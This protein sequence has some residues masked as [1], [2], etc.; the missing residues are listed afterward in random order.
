MKFLIHSK[1]YGDKKV[2]IDD[3]DWE[4][5]SKY[6]W[7]LSKQSQGLL[8]AQ[9]FIYKNGKKIPLKLHRLIMNCPKNKEIDHIDGNG[10]NNQ[11]SNLRICT[12]AENMKNSKKRKDNSSGFKGIH[13]IKQN[14][15][16]QARI[17]VNRKRMP[18]GCYKTPELA[19][20]AYCK[21]S[22]KYH[23]EFGRIK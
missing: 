6:K 19:Y 23:G 10:L 11:K 20:Q 17:Q 13:F 16:W 21:A 9:T 5:V 7:H 2:L 15:R 4:K 8:Y 12:H 3:E 18:L 1:K 22:K 14:K